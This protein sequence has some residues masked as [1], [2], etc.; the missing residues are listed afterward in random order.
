MEIIISVVI[1]MIILLVIFVPK[2]KFK[3]QIASKSIFWM[4]ET[5]VVLIK[6]NQCDIKRVF[7]GLTSGSSKHAK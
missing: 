2:P 3:V 6:L 7:E 5:Y 4:N 1:G